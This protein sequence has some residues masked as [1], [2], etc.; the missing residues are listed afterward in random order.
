LERAHPFCKGRAIALSVLFFCLHLPALEYISAEGFKDCCN[1]VYE[2][3]GQHFVPEE[4]R[5]GHAIYIRTGLLELFLQKHHAKIKEPYILVTHFSDLPFPNKA[6]P[7][8]DDPKILA[9]FALNAELA[10]HPKL[11]PIPIGIDVQCHHNGGIQILNE[12]RTIA[13]QTSKNIP[14][15]LN[16]VSHD[17]VP[18]RVFVAQ[19]F[20]TKPFCVRGQRKPFR[21]YLKD[22]AQAQFVLSPRGLGYDCYRTWEALYLGAIPIIKSSAM[23][24]LFADLP[25]VIVK[26]W[27]EISEPF[28]KAQAEVI[29]KKQFKLEKLDMTYWRQQI[30]KA[31][32]R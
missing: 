30:E 27:R 14:L 15:Y 11:I 10:R 28:L 23:D 26:D 16:F 6:L 29:G 5:H 20:K 7:Y 32:E 4:V 2:R 31:R 13:A 3:H 19:L 18:E 17:K 25:V 1:Y 22:L 21:S 9:C 12:E 24:S 8:L